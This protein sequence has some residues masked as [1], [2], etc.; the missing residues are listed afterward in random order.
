[1]L[2]RRYSLDQETETLKVCQ[3]A[4]TLVQTVKTFEHFKYFDWLNHLSFLNIVD[5]QHSDN[6]MRKLEN[7]CYFIEF[8]IFSPPK[9][10]ALL[11]IF[12]CSSYKTE[13]TQDM[14]PIVLFLLLEIYDRAL[15]A[16]QALKQKC[17]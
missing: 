16:R 14:T 15:H 13:L 7:S 9:K 4:S 11:C 1:M 12:L 6:N 17:R 3:N 5:P 2:T 10:N 8:A